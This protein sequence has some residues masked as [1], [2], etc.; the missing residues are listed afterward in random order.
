MREETRRTHLFPVKL[1]L[2]AVAW[3]TEARGD[4]SES[5]GDG[6]QGELVGLAMRSLLGARRC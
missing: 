2:A 6:S 3:S 5:S 1:M 4:D